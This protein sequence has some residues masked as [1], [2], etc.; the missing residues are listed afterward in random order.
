MKK[1]AIIIGAGPAGLTAAYE[2][3]SHT[4]IV[5]IVLESSG[6]LGGIARTVNYKGNRIDIGGHRFFSKSDRVMAWWKKILPLQTAPASDDL[7]LKRDIPLSKDPEDHDPQKTDLVML[8]RKRFTRV[9]FLRNFFS[10]P[11]RAE[12]QTFKNLGPWRIIQILVSY[13]IIHLRP[14]RPVKNLEDFFINRFGRKLYTIFFKA[15]IE[16]VW[17]VPCHM[18]KPEWG[19]QRI[20]G[21]SIGKAI[22]NIFRKPFRRHVSLDQKDFETSLIELFM[23]PKLGPGQ[24]WQEVASQV[25][26]RGGQVILDHKVVKMILNEGKISQV[27]VLDGPSNEIRV[28]EGEYVFSTMPIKELIYSIEGP[29]PQGVKEAAEGLKYRDFITVGLLINKLKIKNNTRI[30]TVNGS[31]PD[32]WVYIQE[33][34]VKICRLQVYNNWSPYLVAD[35]TKLWIGLEYILDETDDLWAKSDQE[36]TRFAISELEKLGLI[37]PVDVLD[38]TVIRV[39]KA[40]PAYFGTYDR[41]GEIRSFVDGI[42]NLFL[43]GRNGLHRYNNQDHSML[44]A[45]TAVENIV[46]GVKDKQNI[47]SLNV[48]LVP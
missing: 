32:H 22:I 36:F 9:F 15:Y 27:H 3:L 26:A 40:Y 20:K 1:K 8:I 23:Y 5:P 45:M 41:L 48:E 2:L 47:W 37:D 28:F 10:Y 21:L 18:I 35:P 17:G 31:I 13:L 19:G 33:P 29:V 42:D 44:T 34:D 38:Q 24:M 14:I 12:G 25:K 7:Q 30:K 4:D 16:K 39:L 6:D 11:V 46:M 43:I